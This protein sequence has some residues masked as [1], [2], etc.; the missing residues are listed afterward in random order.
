MLIFATDRESSRLRW[1][2]IFATGAWGVVPVSDWASLLE[3]LAMPRTRTI[4]VDPM[5]PG[6]R[7]ALLVELAA[8]VPHRPLLRCIDEPIGGIAVIPARPNTLQ[9]LL[10][11]R[12]PRGVGELQGRLRHCGL[13]PNAGLLVSKAAG[14]S[15]ALLV[16]G[17]RGTGKEL[18]ARLVH[19]LGG[20]GGPFLSVLPGASWRPEGPPGTVYFE[21]AHLVTDLAIRVREAEAAGWRAMAGTRA[22]LE[23]GGVTLLRLSPLRERPEAVVPLVHHFIELHTRRLGLPRRRFDRSLLAL[24]QAWIWPQ[25]ERELDRFVHDV[26]LAVDE[27]AIRAASLPEELRARLNPAASAPGADLEGFEEVVAARLA[28]VVQG[29]HAGRGT[30][31]HGMVVDATERALLR[32]VLARTQGNRKAASRLL[33]VARNTLQSRLERLGVSAASE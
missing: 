16:E 5:L 27:P 1:M 33:G 30:D 2:P 14:S 4:V 26:L 20:R 15:A 22:P 25:N 10:R 19:N 21:S 29:W 32:L 7:P 17:P 18:V 28:P 12:G 3:Q 6:L 23:L 13:G 11:R 8:S 31:L 9:A 24:L